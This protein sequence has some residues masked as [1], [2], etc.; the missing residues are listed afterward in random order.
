MPRETV[1]SSTETIAQVIEGLTTQYNMDHEGYARNL[2]SHNAHGL[3]A[4]DLAR[5]YA[6]EGDLTRTAAFLQVVEVPPVR[7]E[8]LPDPRAVILSEAFHKAAEKARKRRDAAKAT[9]LSTRAEEIS[10]MI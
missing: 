3:S 7:E 2:V 9:F 6:R 10:R 5:S 8:P 4:W 1:D